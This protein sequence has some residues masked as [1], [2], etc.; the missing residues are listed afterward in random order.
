MAA[1]KEFDFFDRPAVK[2]FLWFLLAAVCGLTIVPDV[3]ID[4]HPHFGF[5]G[6]VGFYAFFGFIACA[7]L[8]LA[9]KLLGK[10][11]KTREDYYD[12]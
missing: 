7:V 12:R 5:D 4:R 6:F 2:R 3:F 9:A 11:L 8:I 1:N 10:V